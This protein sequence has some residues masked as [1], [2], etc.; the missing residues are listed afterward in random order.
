MHS[1][2]CIKQIKQIK[3][4]Q[5][6]PS[7]KKGHVDLDLWVGDVP[8]LT[9]DIVKNCYSMAT[10]LRMDAPWEEQTVTNS[11]LKCAIPH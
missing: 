10:G 3:Q 1:H 11:I 5:Y 9:L 6:V 4:L 7:I 8:N 2:N